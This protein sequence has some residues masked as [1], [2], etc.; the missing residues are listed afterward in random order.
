MLEKYSRAT[1]EIN[2][3]KKIQQGIILSAND[4]V[5]EFEDLEKHYLEFIDSA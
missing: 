1:F 4:V 3:S 5:T 2:H